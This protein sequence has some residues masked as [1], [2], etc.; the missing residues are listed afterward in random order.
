MYVRISILV[1]FGVLSRVL[2]NHGNGDTI[3]AAALRREYYLTPWSR[4]PCKS[5]D[6]ELSIHA[7]RG[8]IGRSYEGLQLPGIQTSM[9]VVTVTQKLLGYISYCL[10]RK[11]VHG[12]L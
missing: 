10:Y 1:F 7:L 3:P 4:Q 5:R 12:T 8:E 6:K 11:I 9:Y 2:S